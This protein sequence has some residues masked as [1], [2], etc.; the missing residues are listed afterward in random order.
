MKLCVAS[1]V[2]E[3]QPAKKT[4]TTTRN[5]VLDRSNSGSIER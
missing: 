5:S 2:T 1:V 4:D 3:S